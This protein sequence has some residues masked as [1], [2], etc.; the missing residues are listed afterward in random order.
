MSI[1]DSDIHHT[2]AA[3]GAVAAAAIGD[4]AVHCSVAALQQGPAD[5]G[6]VAAIVDMS[7]F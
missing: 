4:P 5:G 6:M 3:V 7:V 2:K 1:N